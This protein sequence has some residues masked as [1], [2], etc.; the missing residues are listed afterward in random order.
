MC[1]LRPLHAEAAVPALAPTAAPQPAPADASGELMRAMELIQSN[2]AS[3]MES[4]AELEESSKRRRQQD[5]SSSVQTYDGP[6]Y[7]AHIC[8]QS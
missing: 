5:R 7:V 6:A 8:L 1:P 4:Q 2:L 3:L